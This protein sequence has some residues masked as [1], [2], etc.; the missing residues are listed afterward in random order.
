M[1]LPNSQSFCNLKA[2]E[3]HIVFS[4]IFFGIQLSLSFFK[5]SLAADAITQK[6]QPLIDGSTLISKDGSFQMGFFGPPGF[7]FSQKRFLGIWHNSSVPSVPNVIWVANQHN[8][9]NGSSGFLMINTSDSVVLLSQDNTVAWSISLS[10]YPRN[11]VLQLL[12]SGNLVLREAKD[13]NPRNYMWQSFDY[14]PDR[15]LLTSTSRD[16]CDDNRRCGSNGLCFI[17]KSPVCSCFQGY[18]PRAP[19]KWSYGDFQEGCVRAQPLSCLKK[20]GF[21][22][23]SGVKLPDNTNSLTNQS[24]G[25]AECGDNCLSNCSCV[26]YAVSSNAAGGGSGC[27]TWF[28]DLLN[29]KELLD[30]GEDLYIRTASESKSNSPKTK[31][32][33]ILVSVAVV[34]AGTLLAVYFIHRK[35][36]KFKD[37]MRNNNEG[38]DNLELPLFSLST[39]VTAT[40]NFAF[41]RKLGEGGFGSVY[42]GRLEDGQEIAVKRLSE[43]SGQ[44]SNEFKNEV[45]LIAKLQHRNLVRLLGCCVEGEERLLIYEYL[46]NKSLDLYIFDET[47][48]KLLEWPQRFRIICGIGRGLLYLHQDSRLRIIHRDLKASNVLL[49]MEMNP[50]ISDF[51]LARMFGGDQTEGVT[52]KVVGT[53]GYM[54]PEYAIDGQFSVKSDVFSF[55][56]L[57]M[58]LVSGKRSRGFY[59]PDDNLNLIGYAWRLWKTGRY[60]ELIDESLRDSLTLSEVVRCIHVGLL[61]VQQLPEDRPTMSSVILMLGND[62]RL[63]EPKQ[64]GFF[65]GKNLPEA[66]S[67]SSKTESSATYDST[68]TVPEAR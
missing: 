26:A 41:N 7:G 48:S 33:V 51:G 54:A 63:P 58:E 13:G 31:L 50:K 43:V 21:V 34:V 4:F 60:L 55:G 19:D 30:G 45:S 6:S 20:H 10:K 23:Y 15:S 28:G 57:L 24:S 5:P 16:Y 35:R 40:D 36:R 68:V 49:D 61:C 14:Q 67:S 62:S 8:P 64:P 9:I 65:G 37:R 59:D 39:L 18:E 22:K 27:T 25:R 38:Q 1:Y 53:Y 52:R 3:N 29:S 11:P 47:Q 42:K 2:M 56:I 66:Y 17:T 46:P 44:G 12:D 32:A